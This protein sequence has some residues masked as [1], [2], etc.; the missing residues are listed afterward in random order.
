MSSPKNVCVG[1]YVKPDRIEEKIDLRVV[2][3]FV[4]AVYMQQDTLFKTLSITG[5]PRNISVCK[6]PSLKRKTFTS[7]SIYLLLV[8]PSLIFQVLLL[9][10]SYEICLNMT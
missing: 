5:N 6:L 3:T 9:I 2:Q 7:T 1:G 4:Y 10:T 8:C